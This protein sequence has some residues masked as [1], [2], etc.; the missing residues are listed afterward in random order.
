MAEL[1]AGSPVST[2][3]VR[4]WRERS[5]G[6]VRWRGRIEHLQSGDNA[7]FLDL[8]SLLEFVRG[9]GVMAENEGTL[10]PP[11]GAELPDGGSKM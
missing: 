1:S 4:F 11:E 10:A 3:V 8:E 5:R 6:E 7:S 2:F 9:V